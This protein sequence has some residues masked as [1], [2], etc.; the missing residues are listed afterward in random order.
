MAAT[1]WGSSTK[2]AWVKA[3]YWRH[4]AGIVLHRTTG[5]CGRHLLE[6]AGLCRILVHAD[7]VLDQG[8]PV[9]WERGT[10]MINPS[11]QTAA[12]RA[13]IWL[14]GRGKVAK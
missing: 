7:M 8:E 11:Q 14:A 3:N 10:G 9:A 2:P 13:G 4:Q 6:P 1:T 5:P 12:G